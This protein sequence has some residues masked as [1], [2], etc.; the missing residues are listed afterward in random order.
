M[1]PRYYYRNK[2]KRI[3]L[4]L[5]TQL[6]NDLFQNEDNKSDKARE[7]FKFYR[8]YKKWGNQER[9]LKI[10]TIIYKIAEYSAEE[11]DLSKEELR[12]NFKQIQD[13]ARDLLQFFRV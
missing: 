11:E 8:Y 7:A 10:I 4:R 2:E 12:G 1:I 13:Y 9:I 6:Y 5:D 3:H